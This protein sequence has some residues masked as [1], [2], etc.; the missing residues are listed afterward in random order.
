MTTPDDIRAEML[1]SYRKGVY[2]P[3]TTRL[4]QI[5]RFIA[6]PS[7]SESLL[8]IYLKEVRKIVTELQEC[9]SQ[10][11]MEKRRPTDRRGLTRGH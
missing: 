9:K 10:S 11:W 2:A 1:Y 4:R 6:S 8:M 3:S 5:D 7:L